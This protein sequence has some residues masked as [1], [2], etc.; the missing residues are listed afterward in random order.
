MKNG[1]EIKRKRK[2][3]DRKREGN[4]LDKENS[5]LVYHYMFTHI[6]GR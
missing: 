4:I 6:W 1:K 5:T 3:G 2:R